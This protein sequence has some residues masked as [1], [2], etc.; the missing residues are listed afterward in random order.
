MAGLTEYIRDHYGSCGL[1]PRCHCLNTGPWL[2]TSCPQW[3]P[4]NWKDWEDGLLAL[5]MGPSGKGRL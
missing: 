4:V 1:G 2:G 5:R 3:T